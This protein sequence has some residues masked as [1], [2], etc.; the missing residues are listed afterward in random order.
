[1]KPRIIQLGVLDYYHERK[2]PIVFQVKRSKV[3]VVA[4]LSRKTLYAG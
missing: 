4:L 3:K 2:K 1:M